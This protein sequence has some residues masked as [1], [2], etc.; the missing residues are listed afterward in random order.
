MATI[1]TRVEHAHAHAHTI[2]SH[3]RTQYY[4][5]AACELAHMAT[6]ATC[7][8]R[9]TLY[10]LKPPLLR[11]NQVLD[12]IYERPS[13]PSNAL[14]INT[15]THTTPPAWGLFGWCVDGLASHG[16]YRAQCSA[17]FFMLLPLRAVC[18]RARTPFDV[19]GVVQPRGCSTNETEKQKKTPAQHAHPRNKVH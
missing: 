12:N 7:P 3:A 13:R 11:A 15:H 6:G 4:I 5:H 14:C 10:I 9:A 16:E 8:L 1:H 19:V 17:L 2:C 18:A